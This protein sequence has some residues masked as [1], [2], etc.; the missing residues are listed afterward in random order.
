MA[1]ATIEAWNRNL[2][3]W[4][5]RERYVMPHPLGKCRQV[6]EKVRAEIVDELSFMRRCS[7]A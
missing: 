7:E 1:P 2:S 6:L 5:A 4:H 3:Q